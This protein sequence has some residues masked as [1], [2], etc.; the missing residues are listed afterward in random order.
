MS[1]W[2]EPRPNSSP[3]I[4][5][6]GYSNLQSELQELWQRRVEVTKAVAA[7]A[8]EGDRSE[9][10]EY[11]YRKKELR[12]LDSRI[13]YLQRRMPDLKVVSEVS[14]TTKIFFGA[15]VTLKDESGKTIRYRIAG[16]DELDNSQEY[17]SVDSPLARILLGRSC[18]DEVSHNIGSTS[19][20]YCILAVHYDAAAGKDL[21]A[22]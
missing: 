13:G 18:N 16:A 4:T 10:A 12:G 5:P 11:I 6:E 21:R 19:K 1:R 8:A 3:Y 7:A 9:N 17:I 15:W 2:R 14:D 22:P 20:I